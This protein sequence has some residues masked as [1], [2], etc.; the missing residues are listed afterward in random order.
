ML[1]CDAVWRMTLTAHRSN[2]DG[3]LAIT[4]TS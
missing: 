4:E 3:L 1:N 2:S